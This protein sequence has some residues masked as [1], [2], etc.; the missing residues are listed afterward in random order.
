MAAAWRL[1]LSA[2]SFAASAVLPQGITRT[3]ERLL[4]NLLH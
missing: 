3:P 2:T 4:R 1:P